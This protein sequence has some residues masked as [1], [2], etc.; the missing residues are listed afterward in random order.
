[1]SRQPFG[2]QRAGDAGADDQRVAFRVFAQ[3][4]TRR[5]PGRRIPGRAAAAQIGL[6]GIV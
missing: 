3:F 6:F 2:N 1:L 5:M 4:G